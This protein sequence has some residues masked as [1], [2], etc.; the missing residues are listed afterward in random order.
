MITF[1][2]PA[3]R[4]SVLTPAMRSYSR[5]KRPLNSTHNKNVPTNMMKNHINTY[6]PSEPNPRKKPLRSIIHP[7]KVTRMM[8]MDRYQTALMNLTYSPP[9]TRQ[10]TKDKSTHKHKTNP[11]FPPKTRVYL[12][13]T[14]SGL[15]AS[16][17]RFTRMKNMA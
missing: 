9:L 11:N 12:H 3:F 17:R 7:T 10:N 16:L 13:Q 1:H 8:T 2:Y 15:A 5:R 4:N 14:H 6:T